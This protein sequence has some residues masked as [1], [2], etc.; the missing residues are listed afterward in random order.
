LQPTFIPLV[1]E[2]TER[3]VLRAASVGVLL[4]LA[5]AANAV[6]FKG[7]SIGCAPGDVGNN[8]CD[9]A[10]M[11]EGCGFDAADCETTFP[12]KAEFTEYLGLHQIQGKVFYNS[13]NRTL[14]NSANGHSLNATEP[15]SGPRSE[16][17]STA[18]PKRRLLDKT[19][20]ADGSSDETEIAKL[21]DEVTKEEFE[22]ADTNG[23]GLNE[24][25][26]IGLYLY[27]KTQQGDFNKDKYAL[28]AM[29][30]Q[31]MIDGTNF[32]SL[33]SY[34]Q[35]LTDMD[36]YLAGGADPLSWPEKAEKEF[37]MQIF[38][39]ADLDNDN[40]MNMIEG[41]VVGFSGEQNNL[42][43]WLDTNSDGFVTFEE[44]FAI[45]ETIIE[46]GQMGKYVCDGLDII[47]ATSGKLDV[48]APMG[49]GGAN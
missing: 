42:F 28:L 24:M 12:R 5:V 29:A 3:M 48:R 31:W 22:I 20:S 33:S 23:D 36:L 32:T 13:I 4:L 38:E 10:C 18:P 2:R 40:K 9:I 11:T 17:N 30:K 21:F 8:K 7:C 19:A 1:T 47:D 39:W 35:L 41:A 46:D 16:D 15:D 27:K 43:T 44:G 14:R 25:E 26:A 37:A 49:V 34:A 45:Y 6:D